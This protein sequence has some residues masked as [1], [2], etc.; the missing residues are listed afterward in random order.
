MS[1]RK[2]SLLAVG[3]ALATGV[4]AAVALGQ[5]VVPIQITATGKVKPDQAGTPRHPRGV[6]FDVRGTMDLPDDRVPLMPRSVDVWFPKGWRYNGAEHPSCAR[7]V[8]ANGGPARCPAR[9]IVAGGDLGHRDPGDGDTTFSHQ[10]LTVVN[11]GPATLYFWVV[12]QNPARVQ[13]PV[14]AT[15]SNLGSPRWSSRLHAEI[16]QRLQVVAG[17]PLVVDFF[18]ATTRGDDWFSTTSCPGDHRWRAHLR[19]TYASGQ[20]ADT[21]GSVACRG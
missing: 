9:S 20:V 4:L 12:I 14:T 19:L 16:P 17:I 21:G 7:A 8:L 5:D 10:G 2:R 6:W 11:G 3:A 1:A 13:A 15:I 18:H